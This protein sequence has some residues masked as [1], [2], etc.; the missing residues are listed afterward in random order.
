M[1]EEQFKLYLLQQ[2][3]ARRQGDRGQSEF[4]PQ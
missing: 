3:K 2:L 1:A 4:V